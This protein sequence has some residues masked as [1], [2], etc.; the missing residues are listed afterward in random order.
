MWSLAQDQVRD[1]LALLSKLQGTLTYTT[2][3]FTLLEGDSSCVSECFTLVRV[4]GCSGVGR[5]SFSFLYQFPHASF[6]HYTGFGFWE[7]S[8]TVRERPVSLN[9]SPHPFC[10]TLRFLLTVLS[11]TI[12]RT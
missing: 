1:R 12:P 2:F 10:S 4:H 6:T 9:S 5:T 7:D 3:R 11:S 8:T